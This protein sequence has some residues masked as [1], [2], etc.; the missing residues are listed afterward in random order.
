MHVLTLIAPA[1]SI[2]PVAESVNLLA[3]HAMKIARGEWLGKGEAYEFHLPAPLTPEVLH[4]LQHEAEDHWRI[5]IAHQPLEGREKQLLISDMDSTMIHQEC[6][7]ELADMLGIKAQVADITERAMRGELPFEPALRARVGL[8]KGM[9]E[10]ELQRCFATRITM[11]EGARTL[12]ATMKKRGA[13]C[14]LVSGG[15]TFFTQR[16][17]D[18]LGFDAQEA[19]VLHLEEGLLTGSVA[20]PI[21]GKEAKREALLRTCAARGI[22]P[23]QTIAVGDGA[24]DLPM[25]LAAGTGVAFRAK[26]LVR[27]QA[28]VNIRYGDLTALLYVQGIPKS[29][30][31][32]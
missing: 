1:G 7:D 16:V 6:I 17:A 26:P 31:A 21:L 23:Q 8:L 15:F 9:A 10:A 12:L 20:E 13:Y 5:D 4:R 11:M 19:N 3:Q 28:Q 32:E 29:E 2:V 25:L 18:T 24:N 22:S 27:A 14:V 30:W